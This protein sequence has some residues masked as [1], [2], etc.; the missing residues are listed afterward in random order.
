M[1][2]GSAKLG[3]VLLVEDNA[4]Y[5][6]LVRLALRDARIGSPL[7]VVGDGEAAIAY[8]RA[9]AAEVEASNPLPALVLLD[10]SLPVRSGFEVLEWLRREGGF[11]SVPVVVLTSSSEPKDMERA[12]ALNVDGYVVKP[13]RFT[14]LVAVLTSLARAWLHGGA[15]TSEEG[16]EALG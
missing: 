8:L 10:L 4:D 6:L 11:E 16:A 7:H 3:P 12:R 13:A 14:D 1:A 9:G 2:A 15:E 5:A